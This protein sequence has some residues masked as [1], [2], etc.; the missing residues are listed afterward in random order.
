[1]PDKLRST[2]PL[3][4]TYSKGEQPQSQKLTAHAEQSRQGALILEKAIG[5]LWND[6]GE[7]IT[8]D[9][10]LQIPNLARMIGANKYLNPAIYP[11]EYEFTFRENLGNKYTGKTSGK[12]KFVPS[13]S[14]FTGIDTSG[15][16]T[17]L[18]A[19]EY[20]VGDPEEGGNPNEY[21]VSTTDG[22]WRTDNELVANEKL[23]YTVDPTTWTRWD[24][25]FP[26]IIPD[27][28]QEEFTAVRV[29]ESSS[30]FRIHLPPRRP[31]NFAGAAASDYGPSGGEEDK[32]PASIDI[33]LSAGNEATTTALPLK[34]WQSDTV[35]ALDHEHYRYS[36]PKEIR[37]QH[38][39]LAP[40]ASYAAGFMYL[41]DTNT[42]TI[43]SDVLFSKPSDGETRPWIIEVESSSFDFSAVT[44]VDESE[45]SY[46]DT[47]LVLIT[48]GAPLTRTLQALAT[49][50]RNHG[51]NNTDSSSMVPSVSHNSLEF[52]TPGIAT[53]NEHS[54][55]YPTYLP[56]WSPS[57]WNNDGHTNLL[58]RGGSQG[59]AGNRYRD[60]NDNAMLGDLVL[61]NSSPDSNNVFL[62]SANTDDSFKIYFGAVGGPYFMG[63]DSNS[64]T[65]NENL[66]WRKQ[67][68]GDITLNS[69]T[70]LCVVF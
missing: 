17:N 18:V 70:G 8:S 24:N 44:S 32:Y 39:S 2:Q 61:A 27:P 68:S 42:G 66:K 51:H 35:N 26:G 3:K 63:I 54:A 12:L 40:G 6:S 37:D 33:G 28:R 48:C 13:S 41:W 10:P 62:D 64:I 59:L 43:I 56:R 30:K 22:S 31:L 47:G 45:A 55:R 67:M 1:M 38:S 65:V 7:A 29:S 69:V 21:F 14:S 50:F 5:D 23:Q 25:T 4:I 20:L 57:R 60:P 36:L 19:A 11:L 58:S 49:E 34:Y 16:F 53:N 46:N 9:Y 15:Q 52:L